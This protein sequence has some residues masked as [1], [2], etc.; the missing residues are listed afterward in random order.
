[1]SPGGPLR[2]RCVDE[3]RTP[4][5][6]DPMTASYRG[7]SPDR[8]A[9]LDAVLAGHVGAD[10][11]P[12]AVWAVARSD[13]VHVGLAGTM[14]VTTGR[15]V[16]RDSVFRLSSMTKP[17]AAVA[18]L[19]L[20]EECRLRLDQPVDPFLPE[21]A[22][23]R[24]LVRPDGRLDDTVPAQRPISVRDVLTFRLGL[25]MDFTASSQPVL[26]ELSRMGVVSAPPAPGRAPAPDEWMQA[27]GQVP[28]EHQ[29][30]ERWRYHLGAD[31]L[32]V[33]VARVVGQPFDVFLRERI[34]DPLG[35]VD[36]GFWVPPAARD[37]FGPVY[38]EPDGA[39][40]ASVYDPTDG[41]WASPPPSPRAATAWCRPSTT[42]WPS[43]PCCAV[44][45]GRRAGPGC[46]PARPWR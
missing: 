2:R 41:Q 6:D 20:L 26:E 8:L 13:E 30:G 3:R 22:N 34:F 27:L 19:I 39:G 7:L 16:A 18:A 17:L 44:A 38:G 35:M 42:T 40:G 10:R 4:I 36:T 12:G 9:R 29:P 37:R 24:V 25:G 11:V 5:P 33:L 1:M 21:L 45:A 31:V 14:D 28:L 23:R 15:P 43:R 32:G 46:W